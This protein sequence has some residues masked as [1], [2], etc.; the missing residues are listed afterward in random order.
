MIHWTCVIC[1]EPAEMHHIKHVR[2]RLVKHKPKTFNAYLEALRL[3]NRKTLPVC[4]L[5]HDMIHK[6]Q[7]NGESLKSLF[8]TFKVKKVG[9]NQE[10]A[11]HLLAMIDGERRTK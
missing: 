10:K 7:Y 1:Q 2:K 4:R 3:V 11:D 8:E 5:H 9:Y 6:G